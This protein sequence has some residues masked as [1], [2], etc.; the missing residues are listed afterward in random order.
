LHPNPGARLREEILLLPKDLLN[1]SMSGDE[2][3]SVTDLI[4]SS[5]PNQCVGDE[6]HVQDRSVD[7]NS[8]QSTTVTDENRGYFMQDNTPTGARHEGDL[9][10]QSAP[11]TAAG[12]GPDSAAGS[13]AG[14]APA[15]TIPGATLGDLSLAGATRGGEC[16]TLDQMCHR[17][18]LHHQCTL[19]RCNLLM[20]LRLLLHRLLLPPDLPR[21]YS[22]VFAKLSTVY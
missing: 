8:E 21:V 16:S 9:W 13:F 5:D 4:D 17:D 7:E 10:P 22:T 3:A 6:P 12:S 2:Q 11:A 15:S 1:P 19:H 14:S 20:L 18:S